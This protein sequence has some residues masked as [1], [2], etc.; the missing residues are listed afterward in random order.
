MINFCLQGIII[1]ILILVGIIISG[2]I[3]YKNKIPNN[4]EIPVT[5]YKAYEDTESYTDLY[6][7]FFNSNKS[8]VRVKNSETA[9]SIYPFAEDCPEIYL[10]LPQKTNLAIRA[11]TYTPVT[12]ILI[13]KK[14]V[15]L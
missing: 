4:E 1:G 3:L 5:K 13:S 8:Y 14:K 15:M 6:E 2:I 9:Q 7:N 11:R 10:G 12:E